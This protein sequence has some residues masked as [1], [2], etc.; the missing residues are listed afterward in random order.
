MR[1]LQEKYNAI[2]EGSFSKDQFLRDARMQHPTL[3]TQYNRYDDAVII[4]K[5]RGMIFETKEQEGRKTTDHPFI[6]Y[7]DKQGKHHIEEVNYEDEQKAFLKTIP[8]TWDVYETKKEAIAEKE[9]RMEKTSVNEA[10]YK[11]SSNSKEAQH[12]KKG[13]IITGGEVVSVSSGAKTPSG[14]V[15]VV[16]KSKD[17]KTKKHI[18]GKYTKIGVKPKKETPKSEALYEA[19]LTKK[20]LVDYR[21]KPTNELDN[22]PYEQILRGLRV[23]LEIMRIVGTPTPEEY[24]KALG[25]VLKNLEKDKIFYT[26][27]LA[28][29]KK[30]DN[31]HDQMVPVEKNNVVD[32]ANGMEKAPIVKEGADEKYRILPVNKDGKK[33]FQVMKG[34]EVVKVYEDRYEAE[35][36]RNKLNGKDLKEGIKNLIKNLLA[37]DTFDFEPGDEL[38]FT[39]R[40]D[41]N[42]Y[43]GT[44]KAVSPDKKSFTYTDPKTKKTF[45]WQAGEDEE[46][47][48]VKKIVKEEEE[49]FELKI[50]VKKIQNLVNIANALIE[51]AVDEDGDPI[52]VVDTSGTWQEPDYYKPIE[53]DGEK[54]IIKNTSYTNPNK[55]EVEVLEGEALYFDG[56]PTL[57]VIIRLYKK[58]LKKHNIEEGNIF[59]TVSFKDLLS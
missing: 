50:P 55:E 4:L 38:E 25:K 7:T 15:E 8:N 39:N 51:K 5:N 18:W 31:E 11:T 58:T 1:T 53:F 26:N 2:Q 59:E 17:G 24:Q 34:D 16:L 27:Q 22:Y 19:R 52:G 43:Q 35:F 41:G 9:R 45:G 32:K 6:V 10:S 46:K 12:L 40:N 49:D 54:L 30:S 44:V 33:S 29:K 23:E 48:N 56:I 21:Y 37:E 57:Q 13:D 36:N 3:V 14:K 20:S 42:K 28:G 47:F